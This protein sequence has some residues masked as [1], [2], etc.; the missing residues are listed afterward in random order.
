[1]ESASGL[2]I[3]VDDEPDILEVIRSMLEDEGFAVLCLSQPVL[4]HE[5][6]SREPPPRLF[7]LPAMSALPRKGESTATAR[8]I[9][10][11]GKRM[12]TC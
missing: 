3:V 12:I 7:I 10:I 4:A 8:G 5:L 2:V 1:M 9:A 11:S 6:K